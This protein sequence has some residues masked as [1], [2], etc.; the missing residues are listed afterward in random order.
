[1]RVEYRRGGLTEWYA[2]GPLG[3]EQGFTLQTRPQG[4]GPLTLAQR[5]SGPLRARADG[6]AIAFARTAGGPALLTY[7]GLRAVDAAGRT[8]PARM[9]LA[10]D[11]V[12][13]RVDDAGAL[14]P[15]T[16]DP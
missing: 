7:S 9:E 10:G 11:R 16:I 13:L 6:G 15:V 4:A 1:N 3:L 12:L 2:N 14:Y 8:L 5:W